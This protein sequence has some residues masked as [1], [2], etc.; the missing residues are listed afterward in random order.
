MAPC[1]WLQVVKTRFN[2]VKPIL[3]RF[4]MKCVNPCNMESNCSFD[5]TKFSNVPKIIKTKTAGL[6]SAWSEGCLCISSIHTIH[7]QIFLH[8]ANHK[9]S[10]IDKFYELFSVSRTQCWIW[11]KTPCCLQGRPVSLLMVIRGNWSKARGLS[12]RYAISWLI[13]FINT[14]AWTV[15]WSNGQGFRTGRWGVQSPTGTNQRF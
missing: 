11:L 9:W 6:I 4:K 13:N 7:V 1:D 2:T 10:V 15:N 12:M 3:P 14:A 5:L 8:T